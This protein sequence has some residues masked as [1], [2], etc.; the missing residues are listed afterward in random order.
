[1]F[2]KKV[3][4]FVGVSEYVTNKMV[5]L[6][7][8]A[9]KTKAIQNGVEIIEWTPKQFNPG[10]IFNIGIAGQVG[11]WKGHEDLLLAIE[12]LKN[13]YPGL[14]FK[15]NIFG[16]GLPL[17]V[18]QM[19]E[20]IAE[21]QLQEY[22]EWKGFVKDIKNIYGDLQVVCI[23]TRTEEP[24]ATSA[25]EAGLFAMPVIVTNRGGFPEIVKHGHNGF[26]VNAND[27]AEIAGY[28]YQ[29]IKD[30]AKAREM[31]LNHQQIITKQFS[32]RDF[33][34]NWEKAVETLITTK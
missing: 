28:L 25:L 27:P 18:G 34:I 26:I 13:K 16:D 32:Y 6:G 20:L 9:N 30:P 12:I 22:V 10:S 31:G 29:L 4:L 7:I 21:K 2:D 11:A 14:K 23:P 24:F 15:L 17:F 3:K 8:S 19:K 5:N 33:I 1:M